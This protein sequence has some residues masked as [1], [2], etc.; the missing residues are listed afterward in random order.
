MLRREGLGVG[1]PGTHL[2]SKSIKCL[3]CAWKTHCV[4]TVERE[5]VGLVWVAVFG[6]SESS[7]MLAYFAGLQKQPANGAERRIRRGR[8]ACSRE[9]R[10][11]LGL[12]EAPLEGAVSWSGALDWACTAL[13]TPATSAA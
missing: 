5:W 8:R 10:P 2:F 9:A 12:L 11:N 4:F 1:S 13:S 3:L 7:S 6:R